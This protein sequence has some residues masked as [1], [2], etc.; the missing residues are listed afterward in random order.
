MSSLVESKIQ[1]NSTNISTIEE[2]WKKEFGVDLVFTE[3]SFISN[4]SLS[5]KEL[6]E[7]QPGI[8]SFSKEDDVNFLLHADKKENYKQRT[9]I[10]NIIY[11]NNFYFIKLLKNNN[12]F[13]IFYF[14]SLHEV[15]K[16]MHFILFFDFKKPLKQIPCSISCKDRYCRLIKKEDSPNFIWTLRMISRLISMKKNEWNVF[17]KTP[18]NICNCNHKYC[19]L[20]HSEKRLNLLTCIVNILLVKKK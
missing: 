17:L 2:L 19:N 13:N 14:F 6:W 7:Q 16:I 12:Y 18:L 1:K 5:I 4:K 20:L 10:D 8:L 9:Y 3:K 11:Y 15:E